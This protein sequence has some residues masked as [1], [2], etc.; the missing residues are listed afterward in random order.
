MNQTVQTC[1]HIHTNTFT[2]I[3]THFGIQT[4]YYFFVLI[5][6][7]QVVK[8]RQSIISLH[9]SNC[10]NHLAHNL[11]KQSTEFSYAEDSY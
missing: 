1:M 10:L 7:A 8:T 11:Y 2:Y 9:Q 6:L 5:I 3:N 4:Q